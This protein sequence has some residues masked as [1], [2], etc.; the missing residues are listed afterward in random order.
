LIKPQYEKNINRYNKVFL[1]AFK[2]GYFGFIDGQN[3][4]AGKFEFQEIQYWNDSLAW[5][6]KNDLWALMDVF[7]KKIVLADVRQFTLIRDA[8]DEKLAIVR[9][10]DFY[11][12]L[13][14][15]RG[16]V[17]PISFTDLVNIGS[18]EEPLYFTEKH[19]SEAS[20]FVVIYYD[21]N[22]KFLRREVYED[23]ENYERIYC[24]DN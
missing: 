21:K 19:V 14:S 5:V 18:R 7:G 4:P 11:G 6:K 1:T 8:P 12:A 10:K 9:Q 23:V 3:K 13:S 2:E 24:T 17:I 15:T 16:V 20:I 22:G